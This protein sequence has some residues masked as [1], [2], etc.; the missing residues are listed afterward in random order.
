MTADAGMLHDQVVLY[1]TMGKD[2][3]CVGAAQRQTGANA[4]H[5]S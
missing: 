4:V 1:V 5:H 2:M 3:N